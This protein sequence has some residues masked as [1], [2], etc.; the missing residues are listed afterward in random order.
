MLDPACH[1]DIKRERHGLLIW[2]LAAGTDYQAV[3]EALATSAPPIKT[4]R[5]SIVREAGPWILKE[6]TGAW[7]LRLARHTFRRSRYRAGWVA[8]H[9]LQEAGVRVPAPI[10]YAE[11]GLA[12][13]CWSN[14]VVSER[15]DGFVNVEDFMRR[16]VRTAAGP[17]GV[18]RFLEGIADAVNQLEDTGA[19]HDDLSGKNILTR[20]GLAFWFIDL[21]AVALDVPYDDARRLRNH[22]QLYDSFCDEL[23]DQL[24]TPFIMR[25]MPPGTDPRVWMPQVRKGQKERRRL[26]EARWEKEGKLPREHVRRD[27]LPPRVGE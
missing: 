3:A 18:G 6:S 23:H 5:K 11:S 27:H 25:M 21:D 1:P 10:A 15:L 9:R 20:D 26:V 24:L 14:L 19:Y 13:L 7:P 16:L 2:H 22:I 12:G 4:S 17:A 8:A